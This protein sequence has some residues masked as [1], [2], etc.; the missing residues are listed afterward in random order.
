MYEVSW[1]NGRVGTMAMVEAILLDAGAVL[2]S[3]V[4]L[5]GQYGLE[6]V[7]MS[8]P[9]R[10]GRAGVLDI[11]ELPLTPEELADLRSSAATVIEAQAALESA[12]G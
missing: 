3:C 8:V 11:P 9:A 7:Y 5:E 10:L 4:R 12:A 1:R 6:D 2:P